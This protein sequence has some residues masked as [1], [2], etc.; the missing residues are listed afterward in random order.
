MVTRL[1]FMEKELEAIFPC[2]SCLDQTISTVVL[3]WPLSQVGETMV[4]IDCVHAL[5]M[6]RKID[7]VE[8]CVALAF[9]THLT[10]RNFSLSL[11]IA[12]PFVEK[13]MGLPHPS[14]NYINY[15]KTDLPRN[16][17]TLKD[18]QVLLIHGTADRL[19][20][21]QHSMM[22]IKCLTDKAVPFRLQV[23]NPI[24]LIKLVVKALFSFLY[25]HTDLSGWRPFPLS[26]KST[27]SPC[28]GGLLCHLFQI[29]R[30]R[31]WEACRNTTDKSI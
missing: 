14:D 27:F 23:S 9:S 28:N 24:A 7:S 5:S 4:R 8:L 29:W 13:F 30:R 31:R 25:Q 22:L 10:R 3:Q 26:R 19:A 11:F 6:L 21:I 18:K 2:R 15:D 1:P 16:L 12:A 20:S 17:E